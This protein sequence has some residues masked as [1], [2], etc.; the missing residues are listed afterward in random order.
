MLAVGTVLMA[1][2]LVSPAR[3]SE[4]RAQTDS[5]AHPDSCPLEKIPSHLRLLPLGAQPEDAIGSTIPF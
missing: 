2:V 1:W 4:C 3:L 5:I